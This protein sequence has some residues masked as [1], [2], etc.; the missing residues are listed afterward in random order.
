MPHCGPR[1]GF[2]PSEWRYSTLNSRS[3]GAS[4]SKSPRAALGS[5]PE[6]FGMKLAK[7]LVDELVYNEAH[8]EVAMVKYLN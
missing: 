4:P 1:A 5:R 3:L 8:N 2:E 7:T 6:G